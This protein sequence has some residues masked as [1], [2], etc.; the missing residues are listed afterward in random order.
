MYSNVEGGQLCE[1]SSVLLKHTISTLEDVQHCGGD[2]T[3]EDTIRTYSGG[4]G[5]HQFWGDFISTVED[6]QHRWEI[7]PYFWGYHK[8]IRGYSVL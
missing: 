4:G 7:S 2:K 6:A 3:V 5:Y 1:V 8:Y